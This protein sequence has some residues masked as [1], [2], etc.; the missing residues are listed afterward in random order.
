M[1]VI[2]F[3]KKRKVVIPTKE[4]TTYSCSYTLILLHHFFSHAS[5]AILHD[6]QSPWLEQSSAGHVTFT[7]FKEVLKSQIATSKHIL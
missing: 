3:S 6:V 4:T 2:G 1:Q 7:E 5:I